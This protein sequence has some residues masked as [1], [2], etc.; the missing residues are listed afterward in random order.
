MERVDREKM[1]ALT[2]YRKQREKV[3]RIDTVDPVPE[4]QLVERRHH[5]RRLSSRRWPLRRT[6]SRAGARPE[7]TG[8]ARRNA[9]PT[10]RRK[11]RRPSSKRRPAAALSPPRWTAAS[12]SSACASILKR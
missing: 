7:R 9:H 8:R 3:T 6:E 10:C 11:C 2:Y 1:L 12:S 5:F 4:E